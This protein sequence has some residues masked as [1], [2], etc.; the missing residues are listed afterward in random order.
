MQP[1]FLY[2]KPCVFASVCLVQKC[3]SLGLDDLPTSA[4]RHAARDAKGS[5]LILAMADTM[6]SVFPI[7][8]Q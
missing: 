6:I 3:E 2:Q 1:G 7:K 8:M 4:P 5:N